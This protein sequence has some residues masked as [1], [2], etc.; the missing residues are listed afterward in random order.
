MQ[1]VDEFVLIVRC[2]VL[3]SASF[4]AWI[5]TCEMG[6]FVVEYQPSDSPWRTFGPS[7]REEIH[8]LKKSDDLDRAAFV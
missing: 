3:T 5:C 4:E 7:E 6:T 1:R 8:R 2:V